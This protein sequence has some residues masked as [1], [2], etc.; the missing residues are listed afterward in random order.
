MPP[1]W[2][3]ARVSLSPW[4]SALFKDGGPGLSCAAQWLMLTPT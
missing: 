2:P 3:A 4:W 1:L